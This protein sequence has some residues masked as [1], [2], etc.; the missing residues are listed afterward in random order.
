MFVLLFTTLPAGLKVR[1][2][3]KDVNSSVVDATENITF[4]LAHSIN[5]HMIVAIWIASNAN[6]GSFHT[7]MS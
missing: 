4:G 3:K 1:T 7:H 6:S 5:N 2:L